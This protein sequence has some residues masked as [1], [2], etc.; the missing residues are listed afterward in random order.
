MDMNSIEKTISGMKDTNDLVMLAVAFYN[1][2]PDH[3]IVTYIN[4]TNY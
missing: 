2:T 4:T 3:I 1:N